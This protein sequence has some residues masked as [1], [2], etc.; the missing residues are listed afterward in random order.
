M[1]VVVYHACSHASHLMFSSSFWLGLWVLL[2]P[3]DPTQR[4]QTSLPSSSTAPCRESKFNNLNY[5][6]HN[7]DHGE[8]DTPHH[9]ANSPEY[10]V[11][12]R[13]IIPCAHFMRFNKLALELQIITMNR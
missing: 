7:L 11:L 12:V 6:H 10:P 3:M 8:K 9:Q 4:A 5:A 1:Q 2:I 13:L